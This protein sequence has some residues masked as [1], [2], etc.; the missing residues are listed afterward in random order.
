LGDSVPFKR[1]FEVLVALDGEHPP[2]RAVVEA[3]RWPF[4]IR[5][6]SQPRSGAGAARNLGIA[7]AEASLI[8]FLN[9][10]TRPASD[11]L[12]MHVEA[13]ARLGPAILMGHVNWDPE[14]PISDYMRWLAPGG[15]QFHFDTLE[16]E[17]TVPWHGCWS[18]HLSLPR[19]W[20]EDQ[21]FDISPELSV[22]EDSE[23]AFRQAWHGRAIRYLPQ[24]VAFHNHYYGSPDGFRPRARAAGSAARRIADLHPQI[25]WLVLTRPRLAALARCVSMLSPSHWRRTAAWD[26]D[27]RWNF[28]LG[29]ILSGRPKPE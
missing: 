2:S 19:S 9:D 11:C 10:D 27:Y 15:H 7:H 13:Q 26:L 14:S 25:A 1:G 17:A 22:G 18:A 21:L 5:L 6:L 12:A 3:R 29:S 24:A 23:W 20:A 8:L 4:A 28:L 16:A